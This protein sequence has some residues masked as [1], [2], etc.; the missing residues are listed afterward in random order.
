V[1]VP[2]KIR[3]L[4][5]FA[6]KMA[7]IR[8]SGEFLPCKLR[9]ETKFLQEPANSRFFAASSARRPDTVEHPQV[10]QA[11]RHPRSA[12]GLSE[13]GKTL[14]LLV[15]DGRRLSSVGAT[16]EELAMILKQ[17]GAWNGLNLDGGGSSVLALR[18]PDGKVRAVNTPIHNRIP[19]MQRGVATCLGLKYE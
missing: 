5:G 12:A 4:S 8:R 1:P 15:I 6:H 3:S 13:D 14:Y 11:P 18:F 9:S 2:E 7:K 10:Q 16:E 17:L 19:G